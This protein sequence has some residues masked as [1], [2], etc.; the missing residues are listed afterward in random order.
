MQKSAS[1]KNLAKALQDF[2]REM[3]VIAKT[4]TN[5]FFGS[6]YADLGTILSAIKEPLQKA[7]LTFSQFPEENNKLT[8]IIIHPESGEW[9]E[10]SYYMA[11]V[12]EYKKDREGKILPGSEYTTPQGEGSVITY[13]RRYALGAILGLNL[14]EDDDGNA[15]SIQKQA[16]HQAPVKKEYSAAPTNRPATDK[17]KNFIRKLVLEKNQPEFS[18]DWYANLDMATARATIDRLMGLPT[19]DLA[20]EEIDY[21]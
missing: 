16:V 8:S 10:A 14:D 9:I 6:K 18:E 19:V 4:E 3:G 11:P 21:Q 2:H 13:Q 17:Q 7:G 5:P 20:E 12:K 1:I 15:G